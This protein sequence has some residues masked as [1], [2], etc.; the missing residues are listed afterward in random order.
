MHKAK[1]VLVHPPLKN[2]LD[3]GTPMYVDK[4]RGHTPPLGLLYLQATIERSEHCSEIIDANLHGWSHDRAAREILSRDPDVIGLQTMTFTLFD[5]YLLSKEIK[6]LNSKVK[7]IMGGPHPTIYPIETAALEYVDYAFSGEGEERIVSLLE[8]L[9]DHDAVSKIPGI[10]TRINGKVVFTPSHDMI[11]N[12][13]DLHFPARKSSEYK[14]YKS[15]LSENKSMTT[16]I[17]S[18]GC[19]FECIFCNRMGKKYRYHSAQYVLREIESIIDLGIHEIFIHDDTF[20]VNRS[21]VIEICRG[22][23]DRNFEIVWQ[24]RTRVDCVDDE[25]ISIMRNAGCQRLSFGVESGSPRV[26]KAMKKNIDLNKVKGIFAECKRAG[27][28]TLA[29][30]M[31]GNLDEK[32]ED[33]QMTFDLIAEIEPDL[34]QFSIC[35]PYPDTQLYQKGLDTGIIEDDVWKIFAQTPLIIPDSPVWTQHFT[36]EE[37]CKLTA[38]AYRKFYWKPKFILKQLMK[39]NSF[40]HFI[41]LTRGAIG[42]LFK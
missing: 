15:V 1:I 17:T 13:D 18:R 16:M 7:I 42:M 9:H 8:N 21:R 35:S 3:A 32:Q 37:L 41:N 11:L 20:T 24:A 12:L 27:M 6:K 28:I 29:D 23:K 38:S 25:L 5:S 22:I 36:K 39:L 34:I 19:P 30:F 4:S 31:F 10:A 14:K 33:I 40:N 26:L 2:L